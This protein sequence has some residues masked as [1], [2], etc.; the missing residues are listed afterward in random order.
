MTRIVVWE[1]G[2]RRWPATSSRVR[3]RNRRSRQDR[4]EQHR[5]PAASHENAVSAGIEPPLP[6]PHR[7]SDRDHRRPSF[8]A[9]PTAA[10]P[11]PRSGC[12]MRAPAAAVAVTIHRGTRSCGG[13]PA[14]QV[15]AP[16]G[17]RPVGFHVRPSLPWKWHRPA[18]GGAVGHHVTRHRRRHLAARRHAALTS[19]RHRGRRSYAVKNVFS[20]RHRRQRRLTTRRAHHARTRR[21]RRSGPKRWGGRR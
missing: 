2:A 9:T 19:R 13:A 15:I 11:E 3:R 21:D 14:H 4:T 7:G 16:A 1:R 8:A 18:D 10:P 5:A 6:G 20:D 12:S 17:L